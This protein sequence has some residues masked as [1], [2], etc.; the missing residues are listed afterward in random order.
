MIEG[1]HG[2][3]MFSLGYSK[4]CW[5]LF[6][7]AKETLKEMLARKYSYRGAA[8]KYEGL[9]VSINSIIEVTQFFLWHQV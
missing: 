6:R 4:I 5:I 3:V 7:N 1:F 8:Q 9:K 2:F